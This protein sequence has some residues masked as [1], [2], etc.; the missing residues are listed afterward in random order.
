MHTNGMDGHSDIVWCGGGAKRR[1]GRFPIGRK[2][3]ILASMPTTGFRKNKKAW[4]QTGNK[5][6]KQMEKS[7]T[8]ITPPRYC[9]PEAKNK[10]DGTKTCQNTLN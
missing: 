6:Q 4:Q 10:R 5:N 1:Y 7:T 3:D 2:H 8:K 9:P